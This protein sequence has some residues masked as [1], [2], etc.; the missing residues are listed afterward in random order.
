MFI[1][2]WFK[3]IIVWLRSKFKPDK[4]P[5]TFEFEFVKE[6]IKREIQ[7]SSDFLSENQLTVLTYVIVHNGNVTRFNLNQKVNNKGGKLTKTLEA[8]QDKK[9]IWYSDKDVGLM[10]KGTK[11]MERVI[12]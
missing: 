1:V 3:K 5:S 12:K 10:K 6:K 11:I 9:Y 7:K 4:K 2:K 8:L